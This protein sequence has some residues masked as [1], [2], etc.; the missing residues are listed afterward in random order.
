[1]EEYTAEEKLAQLQAE[2]G[3]EEEDFDYVDEEGEGYGGD[4]FDYAD[5]EGEGTTQTEFEVQSGTKRGW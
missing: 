4:D 5:E 1:M 3:G 2:M